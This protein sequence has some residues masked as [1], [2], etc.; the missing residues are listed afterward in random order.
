[1]LGTLRNIAV[2]LVACLLL[3]NSAFAVKAQKDLY[4]VA[5]GITSATVIVSANA[6][7]WEKHAAQDLVTYI[8]RMT[9][10][11]PVLAD[12]AAS[13][14]QALRSRAPVLV[15]GQA[16]LDMSPALRAELKRVAKPKPVLRADAIALSRQGNHIL[17]A[18]NNDDAHYYAVA[19]LLRR[20]GCRWYMPGAFGESIPQLQDLRVG[21]LNH[22]YAPPFEVRRYWLSWLGDSTGKAEFMRRNFFNDVYVPSGHALGQYTKELIPPDQTML[23]V[24]ISDDSTAA[25]VA[26]KILPAYSAGKDVSLSMED[27][28]YASDSAQDK[29]LAALQ[30]D[31]YFLGPSYTDAFMQL[32]NNVAARLQA[33]APESRARLGFLAY[34]NMTLPPVQTPKAAAPLVAY[35]APIDIDPIHSIDDPRSPPRQEYG[36]IMNKWASVMQGRLVIYDYDQSMLVWRDLPNPSHQA[37]RRDVKAYQAAGILGVDTESRGAMATTLT[38]LHLRGQLLWNPDADVD[39]LLSEFYTRFYGHAAKPMAQYWDAIF[40]AWQD[41]LV[42]E[43]EYFVVPA[44]YTPELVVRLRSHL[45]AAEALQRAKQVQPSTF[46][47]NS[48]AD[49]AA[50]QVIAERLR[51][52]RLGFEV[53]AGYTDMVRAAATNVDYAAAVAAGE[54]GLAAREQLADMDPTFTT[55][56]KIGEKGYTWWPGEVQQYRELLP[57]TNGQKGELV[58]RLPLVWNFRRDPSMRGPAENWPAQPVSDSAWRTLPQPLSLQARHQLAGQWEPLRTD[59]YAQAQGVINTDYQSYAGFAWYHTEVKLD[60]DQIDKGP[61]HLRFPGLFNNAAIFINGSPIGQR[62]LPHALWWANDYRNEWDVELTGHVKP[63]VNRLDLQ[64]H[65]PNHFGGIFRRPFIYRAVAQ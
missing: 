43:H 28:L 38:N 45:E 54:R 23:N 11:R 9:G 51:F 33:A 65:I 16:A 35:L 4:I 25:H 22:A 50:A 34:S 19:E 10:A 52:T 18:G 55:F 3:G 17:L 42:T 5:G 40:K 21:A 31:K 24:P 36:G 20:W 2:T 59:L 63:G 49:S 60:A 13:T 53:L 14:Q 41:T 48:K 44:I 1:M 29:A 12:T 8:E 64:L 26:A 30:Y 61:L 32:Y 37:F 56:R 15:V 62:Q 58:A 6:G 46:T 27:G 57:Y 39:A 7:P 47:K